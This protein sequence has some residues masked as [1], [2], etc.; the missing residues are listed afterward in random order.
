MNGGKKQPKRTIRIPVNRHNW[1]LLFQRLGPRITLRAVTFKDKGRVTG[2]GGHNM[3][4]IE[5]RGGVVASPKLWDISK[6]IEIEEE[7]S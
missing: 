7:K 4:E 3:A 1:V 5:A 6:F 2:S